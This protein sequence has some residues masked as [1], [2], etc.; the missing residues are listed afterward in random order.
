MGKEVK[1]SASCIEQVVRVGFDLDANFDG[2]AVC[3]PDL[4]VPGFDGIFV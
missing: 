2:L 3:L 4:I 1:S